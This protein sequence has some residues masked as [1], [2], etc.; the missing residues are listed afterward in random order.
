M[1]ALCIMYDLCA[2]KSS[3]GTIKVQIEGQ[4]VTRVLFIQIRNYLKDLAY[5]VSVSETKD[6]FRDFSVHCTIF[7]LYTVYTVTDTVDQVVRPVFC[8]KPT[9][10]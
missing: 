9:A 4:D 1:S 3:T 2:E 5:V 10:Q 8:L 6:E 7:V